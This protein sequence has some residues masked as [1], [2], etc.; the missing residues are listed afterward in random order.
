MTIS[1][2]WLGELGQ[3]RSVFIVEAESITAGAATTTWV[4]SGRVVYEIFHRFQQAPTIDLAGSLSPQF[5]KSLFYRVV[6]VL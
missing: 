1:V 4:E 2:Q 6:R 3:I 5:V